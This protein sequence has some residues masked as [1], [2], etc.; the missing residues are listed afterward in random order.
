MSKERKGGMKTKEKE[1]N[2]RKEKRKKVKK[3]IKGETGNKM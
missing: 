2:M 1:R 3:G